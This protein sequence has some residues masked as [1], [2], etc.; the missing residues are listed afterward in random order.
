MDDFWEDVSHLQVNAC[1]SLSIYT[2]K[3]CFSACA[4]DILLMEEILHHLGGF[5]N[6]YN[7]YD[8]KDLRWCKISSIS[9]MVHLG[10]L[11]L[12]RLFQKSF[13]T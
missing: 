3:H 11:T 4:P 2:C 1:I 5:I 8:F 12:R 10:M 13:L 9:S 6:Y 7:S